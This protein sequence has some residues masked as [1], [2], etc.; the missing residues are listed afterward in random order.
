MTLKMSKTKEIDRILFYR[1]VRF[2]I[3]QFGGVAFCIQLKI[4]LIGGDDVG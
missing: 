2:R 1:V 4:I 3:D